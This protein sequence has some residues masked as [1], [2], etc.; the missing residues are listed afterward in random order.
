[1]PVVKYLLHILA[2]SLIRPRNFSMRIF[3]VMMKIPCLKAGYFHHGIVSDS[4][5]RFAF[6]SRTYPY[7]FFEGKHEYLA[8]SDLAC[9]GLHLYS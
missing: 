9:L 2:L 6:F 8:V 4:D 7:Y 5:R 3:S 1:M